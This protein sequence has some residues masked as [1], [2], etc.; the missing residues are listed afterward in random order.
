M[1]PARSDLFSK[2]G[3]PVQGLRYAL[4]VHDCK[5]LEE[6]EAR[7]N[8]LTYNG[9]TPSDIFRVRGNGDHLKPG[10]L[11]RYLFNLPSAEEMKRE[12]ILLDLGAGI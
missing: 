4:S 5:T 8:D 12:K 9:I 6:L 2:S 10:K 7:A 3:F 11:A 1:K